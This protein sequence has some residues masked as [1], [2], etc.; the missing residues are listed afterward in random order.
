L[1]LANAH[2]LNPFKG[3]YKT[4]DTLPTDGFDGAYLYFKDTSELTGQTTIYRWNGTTYADTGTVVDTSNVQT[5]ETGQAVNGVAID[6][7]GLE[8]P[9][10]NALAKAKDVKGRIEVI[11]DTSYRQ[12][13]FEN[14]A[15]KLGS[16]V[17]TMYDLN[18]WGVIFVEAHAGDEM[19]IN[20]GTTGGAATGEPCL[21]QMD[22]NKYFVGYLSYNGYT[23]SRTWT[24][25]NEDTA[26]LA[27]SFKLVK[28]DGTTNTT[29]VVKNG[30]P[31]N[32]HKHKEGKDD[33]YWH[34][35][36]CGEFIQN[37]PDSNGN[38]TGSGSY[39][40][41]R[42]CTSS[43]VVLPHGAARIRF[44]DPN[45]GYVAMYMFYLNASGKG[46]DPAASR[47]IFANEEIAVPTA[48]KSTR[49][50]F[51]KVKIYRNVS[52]A[53]NAAYYDTI[54]PEMLSG[55]TIEYYSEEDKICERNAANNINLAAAKRLLAYASGVFDREMN[56]MGKMAVIGHISDIHG[57]TKRLNNFL[58]YCD[59]K[60]VDVAVGSGDMTMYFH[61][62]GTSF[63]EEIS[64]LHTTP[65][66]FCIGNH[67]SWSNAGSNTHAPVTTLFDDNM[68][69]LV[70]KWGYKADANNETAKCYYYKDFDE[71]KL[72]VIAI[73]YYEDGVYNG[74]LG[75]T[76]VDWFIATLAT[77]PA[78]YGV[79]VV[80]HS[81]EDKV[82]APASHDKFM[83]PI[84]NVGSSYQ[85]DG[86]HL[87]VRPISLI[88]DAFIQKTSTSFTCKD[89]KATY[90]GSANTGFAD[91][92]VIN[93]VADFS[94]VDAS[95]EFVA[96]LCGHR[97][98]DWVGYYAHAAETQ[99][100]LGVTCGIGIF[101]DS[102]NYAWCDQS[103]LPRGGE[104]VAQDAFNIYVIDRFNKTV[105]IVRVGAN[106]TQLLEWRD[107][108]VIPY[109]VKPTDPT[110]E[111]RV[112]TLE[113]E[114]DG[115]I[116]PAAEG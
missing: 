27:V 56:G 33:R 74:R 102:S 38:P 61:P 9:A 109:K 72:R 21:I 111:E 29:P 106:R 23:N 75:Q 103:D 35:L 51:Y 59:A 52:A 113:N 19:T 95:T 36:N 112:D 46:L 11:E 17:G 76:Q 90:T 8:N 48:A 65:Y 87:E 110:L 82:E 101:G 30:I 80:L 79:I 49:F 25:S 91:D 57:D 22:Y 2:E 1:D 88:I 39:T 24:V 55:V 85:P 14:K 96:F 68:S 53:N 66:L 18:G 84:P 71:K 31:I 107:C 28:D 115:L 92:E 99:L 50:V 64:D 69:H 42:V 26:V 60:G 70:T 16:N 86:F 6:G 45:N 20:F 108:M 73:N 10:A 12:N 63:Q 34:K 43:K 93:V 114:V 54:T 89:H 105:K 41:V 83:Q 98:E 100:A 15:I 32:I 94:E 40:N 116:N 3:W 81:P 58:D 97:H 104:G 44:T 37:A 4:G 78:G 62:D 5:F 77:T 67:E 13:Y 47:I 7:T